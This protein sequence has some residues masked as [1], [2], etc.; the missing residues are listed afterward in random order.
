MD[1]QAKEPMHDLCCARCGFF[2]IGTT[3][4][5]RCPT[6]GGNVWLYLDDPSR[7]ALDL[8]AAAAAAVA[9]LNLF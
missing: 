2:T 6:C 3:P 1:P 8:M 9:A 4:P 7:S 5:W